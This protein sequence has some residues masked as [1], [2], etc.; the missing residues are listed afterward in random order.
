LLESPVLLPQGEVFE[1]NFDLYR[2]KDL[3]FSIVPKIEIELLD[4]T[5]FLRTPSTVNFID[6]ISKEAILDMIVEEEM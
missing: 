3:N 5:I 2:F 1:Y 6:E 4:T